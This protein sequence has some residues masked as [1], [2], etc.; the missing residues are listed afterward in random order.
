M[1]RTSTANDYER[2]YRQQQNKKVNFH[3]KVT[4][5]EQGLLPADS[6]TRVHFADGKAI[7]ILEVGDTKTVYFVGEEPNATN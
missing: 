4:K 7:E 5:I 1:S 2:L 6:H 3:P